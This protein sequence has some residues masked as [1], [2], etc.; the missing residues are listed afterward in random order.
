MADNSREKSEAPETGAVFFA[1][2]AKEDSES[3]PPTMMGAILRH[4]LQGPL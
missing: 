2:R 1:G 4:L 3:A